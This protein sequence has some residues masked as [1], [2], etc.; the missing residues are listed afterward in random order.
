MKFLINCFSDYNSPA[1]ILEIRSEHFFSA[2][3]EED[4]AKRT[5]ACLSSQRESPIV[6]NDSIPLSIIPQI[7]NFLF[8]DFINNSFVIFYFW[9]LGVMEEQ[10]NETQSPQQ[11]ETIQIRG[12]SSK[13]HLL[14]IVMIYC[15]FQKIWCL[16]YKKKSIRNYVFLAW[17]VRTP[18]R[19][20]GLKCNLGYPSS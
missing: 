17:Y 19:Y 4:K 16:N 2:V 18:Y 10:R 13:D 8:E 11:I 7:A 5:K 9:I 14:D 3:W 1:L 6:P 20:F 12:I 15:L